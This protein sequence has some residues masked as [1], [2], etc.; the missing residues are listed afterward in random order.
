VDERRCVDAVDGSGVGCGTDRCVDDDRLGKVRGLYG[1]VCELGREFAAGE[2]GGSVIDESERCSV[3]EGCCTSET[4]YDLVAVW[5]GV[6]RAQSVADARNDM[7]HSWF[8]VA[9]SEESAGRGCQAAHC[10]GIDA[11]GTRAEPSIAREQIRGYHDGRGFVH[12]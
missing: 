6:H 3:P 5:K 10:S 7:L 4:E 11:G 9:G 8:S 12:V 2:M 1:Y